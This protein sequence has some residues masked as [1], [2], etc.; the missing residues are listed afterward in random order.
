MTK[1]NLHIRPGKV[2]ALFIAQ[3]SMDIVLRKTIQKNILLGK[4]RIEIVKG[5]NE[6]SS[7]M[8]PQGKQE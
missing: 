3:Q 7:R 5:E 4:Q 8:I 6:I 1:F 2:R